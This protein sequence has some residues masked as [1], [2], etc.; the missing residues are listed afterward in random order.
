MITY[1]PGTSTFDDVGHVVRS[2]GSKYVPV[3]PTYPPN[4]VRVDTRVFTRNSI[5]VRSLFHR[6]IVCTLMLPPPP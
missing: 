3:G 6:M 2:D 1:S 4:L 5:I